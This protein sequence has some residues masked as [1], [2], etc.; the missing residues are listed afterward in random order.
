MDLKI[1]YEDVHLLCVI[2]PAGIPSEGDGM[3]RLVGEYLRGDGAGDAP[4]VGS[5]HRLDRDVSGVMVFAKE[6]KTAAALSALIA[7]REFEKEY[8][9]IVSGE[10]D[11]AGEMQDLLYHDKGRNKTFVV[12]R[13]RRGVREASLDYRTLATRSG[14]S[15]VHVH[16]HTGRTHQ[17]RVQFASRKHPLLGDGKYGG[18]KGKI[19]LFSH[20]IAF[21]HPVTKEEMCFSALPPIT[22]AWETFAND[23]PPLSGKEF[24]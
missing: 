9:A 20:K 8:L 19:A 11:A 3:P 17:I 7:R 12:K 21:V 24:L 5:V 6:E 23:L 18:G 14:N 10:T 16:L 22:D 2:K 13:P 1:L 15:L 4:Y